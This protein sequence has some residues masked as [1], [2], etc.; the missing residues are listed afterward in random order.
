M[1]SD[2]FATPGHPQPPQISPTSKY[3]L[4]FLDISQAQAAQAGQYWPGATASAPSFTF[5]A[6]HTL[7]TPPTAESDV[8]K[9][10]AEGRSNGFALAAAAAAQHQPSMASTL[11]PTGQPQSLTARRSAASNL[12]NFELPPPSSISQ[13][14]MQYTSL[15]TT[16]ST[17][18][19]VS[20]G[21]L[22]TP[23]SNI[24]GDSLSPISSTMSNHGNGN[25]NAQA[26]T[27]TGG[28]WPPP[29]GGNTSFPL[30]T[31]TT[32]QP[33][34]QGSVNPLFPPRGMFSPSLNSVLR[35]S[36][37]SPAS[38]DGLP[39]PP[40]FDMNQL[41]PF[42]GTMSMS[43]PSSLPSVAAQQQQQAL[44]QAY[45]NVHSPVSA[46]TSQASPGNAS[47]SFAQ[48]RAP[49]TPTYYTGSQPS[50][51]PQ[52]AHFPAFHHPSSAQQSPMSASAPQGSRIS[53]LSAQ[54]PGA[55][56]SAHQQ[57]GAFARPYASYNL[58]AMNGPIMTNVHTPGGQMVL[59]G[60]MMPSHGLPGNMMPGFSSGASAQM[61]QMY[62][63]H[64][65]APHNERPFKCDQ[66]PQSFNRNHDLKRHKR[67][68]LAVKPFP[69]GHCEKSFSRKDA[70]KVSTVTPASTSPDENS[71]LTMNTETHPGQE[72][73]QRLVHVGQG[74][75]V[76]VASRKV[77][78][79]KQR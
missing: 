25:Q 49:P 22:L 1:S 42:P 77:G 2:Y 5:P 31:G 59:A 65:Q 6:S 13:K 61:Q 29:A 78:T 53:P 23:P 72:L 4:P 68:H 41:P 14:F 75:R 20:V 3:K 7:P 28:F 40:P 51:T 57:G 76:A 26:Y 52:N 16:Q 21:N 67:I 9:P 79:T 46:P 11:E 58:P 71:R 10:P 19:M 60:G 45:M 8:F 74:S 66:C 43:T 63:G 39:P 27:P 48:Q 34:N 30:G 56:Q 54:T 47:D 15:P 12:P 70:L 38:A 73:R 24:P 37:N 18:A 17:P 55:Q 44:N 32:P 62:G 36:S 35:N 50:S 64:Q 69:C 33:W